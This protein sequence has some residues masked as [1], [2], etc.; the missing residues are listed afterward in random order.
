MRNPDVGQNVQ[1][2]PLRQ[3]I[4]GIITF[5]LAALAL[6]TLLI[7]TPTGP[8]DVLNPP[9]RFESERHNLMTNTFELDKPWPLNF[10]AY[11]FDPGETTDVVF[12]KTYSKGIRVR[13]FGGDVSGS[14]ILTGDF[15]RSFALALQV[16][17]T[18]MYGRG[19]DLLFAAL[20]GLVLTFGYVATVQRL[21]LRAGHATTLGSAD[22]TRV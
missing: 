6:Y 16:P 12:G 10:L 13:L 8:P 21:R 2:H 18:D 22:V 7:Y 17:A 5:F 19:F 1:A 15:G 20:L 4:D 11:M 14:G 9:P 3:F